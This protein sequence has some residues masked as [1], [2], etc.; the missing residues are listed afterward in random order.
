MPCT[1]ARSLDAFALTLAS[2][3]F[4]MLCDI[5]PLIQ[6]EE[7]F[8]KAKRDLSTAKSLDFLNFEELRFRRT[9]L[10]SLWL[11]R[12]VCPAHLTEIL[13]FC[14]V[15]LQ[16]RCAAH[17]GTRLM[18]DI[19]G[20]TQP[21]SGLS[22]HH[23]ATIIQCLEQCDGSASDRK[24]YV[25]QELPPGPAFHICACVWDGWLLDHGR[26]SS[27]LPLGA[28]KF[29][30]AEAT[31]FANSDVHLSYYDHDWQFSSWT[32]L[33]YPNGQEFATF[34]DDFLGKLRARSVPQWAEAMHHTAQPKASH[35]ELALLARDLIESDTGLAANISNQT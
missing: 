26:D 8:S 30:T 25:L 6:F 17:L 4:P 14:C 21:D 22:P 31:M 19:A 10:F 3:G 9:L 20:L 1:Q 34:L 13:I 29:V 12:Q 18:V 2:G 33:V 24:A 23:L 28:E 15:C 7:A 27:L 35:P 32:Q 11:G 16:S 5:S